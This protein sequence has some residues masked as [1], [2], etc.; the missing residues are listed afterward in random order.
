MVTDQIGDMRAKE[1]IR[2]KL[3]FLAWA[4]RRE[5]EITGGEVMRAQRQS[6]L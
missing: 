5:G 3:R 4:M 6:V 2:K 1:Q